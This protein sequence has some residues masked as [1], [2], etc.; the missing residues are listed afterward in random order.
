MSQNATSPISVQ[1][2]DGIGLDSQTDDRSITSIVSFMPTF[3]VLGNQFTELLIDRRN[4]HARRCAGQVIPELNRPS[5][6]YMV[7][8]LPHIILPPSPLK[9]CRVTVARD[10]QFRELYDWLPRAHRKFKRDNALDKGISTA[11]SGY[12]ASCP[13]ASHATSRHHPDKRRDRLSAR[14]VSSMRQVHKSHAGQM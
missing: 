6:F 5:V 12:A 8:R 4:Q 14:L 1:R 7:H 2:T 10:G 3:G 9:Y 11:L 13:S